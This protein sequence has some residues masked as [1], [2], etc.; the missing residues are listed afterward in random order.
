MTE[1]V[2][3]LESVGPLLLMLAFV[4][5]LD[6][7]AVFTAGREKLETEL[8]LNTGESPDWHTALAGEMM[9]RV[10]GTITCA[11]HVSVIV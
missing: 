6:C 8:L 4:L 3:P 1:L 11:V 2:G 5:L 7:V 9:T 10:V